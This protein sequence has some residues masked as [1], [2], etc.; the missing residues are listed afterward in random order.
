M[1]TVFASRTGNV[2]ALIDKLGINDAIRIES[3]DET[4]DGDYVIFTYTDGYGEVPFEV[5]T[6]LSNNKDALKAVISSGDIGHGEEVFAKAGDV[7]AEEYGVPCLYKFEH[8][9]T[10]DDVTNIKNKLAEM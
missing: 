2:E 6:F 3:G 10:D 8:D 9:G 5:D 1:K 4:V 7:I